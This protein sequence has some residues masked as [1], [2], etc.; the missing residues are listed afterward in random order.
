[1]KTKSLKKIFQGKVKTLR[2][3]MCSEEIEGIFQDSFTLRL[4][5][6]H[7]MRTCLEGM[8]IL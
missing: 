8:E 7:E 3:K 2:V 6:E 1:M 4:A 5:E